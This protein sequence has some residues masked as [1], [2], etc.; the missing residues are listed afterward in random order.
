MDEKDFVNSKTGKVVWEQNGMYF[1][2]EPNPLPFRDFTP[3]PALGNALLNTALVLGRL[4]G[5]TQKFTPE[6]V[7]LLR[8]PFIL[9]EA[10]LSS[11]I[12]GTR[13]TL[14]DVYKEEK[15]K[16][17]D[18]QKALDNEEIRNY[19]KALEYGLQN[20]EKGLSEEIVKQMHT[21]LLQGV[22]GS[23]KNPGDYKTEQNAIGKRQDTLETAKFVPASPKETPYL[24]KNLVEFMN[25]DLSINA[26]YKTAIMHYQFE[27]IHPFRDGNG[28]IGRLLIMLILSKEKI[29]S[30]PLLY[31][32]EYFNRN[33]STYTDLLYDVSSKN[34]IEEWM[35]FFLK[36]LE[37]QANS[38]LRLIQALENYREEL[39]KNMKEVS[40]S[41]K[42]H[43]LVDLIFKNPF[44]TITDV[45][46][47]LELT[48]PW[49]SNLVHKLE[50]KGVLK[51]I[52][53]K[54]SRKIFVAQRILNILEG[55]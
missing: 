40:E 38:S 10:T 27:A 37:T 44:I 21:F 42:M 12:E 55:R 24:M 47:K 49:A 17:T 53:G 5:M 26:L 20:L 30:Q 43:L 19:V 51:E 22:R 25:D 33:R 23:D 52:T 45:S 14:T 36:A 41:P 31:I 16:E 7:Y 46:E 11:E 50:Q 15:Q 4:D 32:S 35:L 3:S 18:A 8:T 13:S 6:E 39:Q 34:K 48:I 28:R 2:F 9:K 54:K 29:L 1:R